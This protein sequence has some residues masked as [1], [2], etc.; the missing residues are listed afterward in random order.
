MYCAVIKPHDVCALS[1]NAM[2]KNKLNNNEPNYLVVVGKYESNIPVWDL[3]CDGLV[4]ASSAALRIYQ[5]DSF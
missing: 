1:C 2:L 5:S 3:L 4:D